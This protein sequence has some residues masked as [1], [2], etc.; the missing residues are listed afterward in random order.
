VSD[1]SADADP[2]PDLDLSPR[3]VEA[4]RPRRRWAAWV[5][6]A[7]L[8]LGFGFVVLKMLD[9]ATLYFYNADEA[10]ERRDE[11]GDDRFRLQGAVVPGTIVDTP[12]GV[13]FTVVFDGAQVDVEHTGSPPELFQE[14]MPVVLEGRWAGEVY[15][16]DEILVKH[17][18]VYVEENSGRL[19]EADSQV[20]VESD[21]P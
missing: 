16:S 21:S 12:T 9:E 4:P 8:V 20:P 3:E 11:L 10:V 1:R 13:T 15:E 7:A 2:D 19:D 5:L 6:G 18:E 17:D 14:G